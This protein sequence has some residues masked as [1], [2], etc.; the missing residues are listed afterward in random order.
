MRIGKTHKA[1]NIKI[2]LAKALLLLTLC[3]SFQAAAQDLKPVRDKQTKKYGYQAKNKTWVIEPRFDGASRFND[4]FAEVTLDGKKGLIDADGQMIL[5]AEYDD[6]KKFDKNGLCEVIRKE[7]KTKLHGVADRSGRIIVPV[8]CQS[9]NIPKKGGLITAQRPSQ[10]EL[11][12]GIPLWGVYDMDGQEIFPP[13]FLSAPSFS[14]GTGIAKSA[15]SGLTGVV[16]EQGAVLLPFEYLA[17]SHHGDGFRT[18]DPDFTRTSWNADLLRGESY[19]QPG[20]IIPYDPMDDPVRAAAWHSG[21]IGIRLH[22]NQVKQM[23][24]RSARTASCRDL[25][26]DWGY[27]RFLRLE[28]FLAETGTP[29]TMADPLSGEDYT[30]KALLYEADGSFVEEV[31]RWG[32]LEAEAYD[33]FIYVAEGEERWLIMHDPNALAASF[34]LTMSGN[35]QIDHRDVYGG[36][37]LRQTELERLLDPRRFAERRIDI[38]E[39][40]NIGV[41]SYLPP[42]SSLQ[43]TR[44]ERD[45]MRDPL[46]HF[47]FHMEDVRSCHVRSRT[48]GIEVDIRDALVCRFEDR[49]SDPYYS[50][51]GEECIFWGPNNERTVRLSLQRVYKSSNA[52]VD[53]VH[54]TEECYQIILSLYEEDGNWLRT[55]GVAPY[56]DYAQEGILVFERLGIALLAPDIRRSSTSAFTVKMPGA[57]PLPHTLSALEEAAR[58]GFGSPAPAGAPA[59]RW[60]TTR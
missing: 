60:R 5:P 3:C 40:D 42:E 8:D 43:Y 1:M 26:L 31:S 45:A 9:V 29:D 33:G 16:S 22:H 19:R 46:F 55:L 41:T 57:V 48:D 36:L 21:C 4:G 54:G 23:E 56:A 44:K 18:L 34:S 37:G 15:L 6:I 35:R 12:E 52:T 17:I 53:D 51:N 59:G 50:M 49:F 11:L 20:A 14:G 30:L 10:D 2:L 28:P 32:Y 58:S 24:M 27:G 47:P 39:G 38:I 7:G 25:R 13:Q